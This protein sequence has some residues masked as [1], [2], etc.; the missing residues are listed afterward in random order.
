MDTYYAGRV[1]FS[2]EW[3][4]YGPMGSSL[5]MPSEA[6]AAAAAAAIRAIVAERRGRVCDRRSSLDW[7]RR[8]NGQPSWDGYDP[9]DRRKSFGRRNSGDRRVSDV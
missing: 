6:K 1:A 5:M 3:R 2:K 8:H 7:T 9:T 4:V